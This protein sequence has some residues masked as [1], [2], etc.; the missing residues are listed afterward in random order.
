[1]DRIHGSNGDRSSWA[2]RRGR[3]GGGRVRRGPIAELATV[4][5]TVLTAGLGKSSQKP[6]EENGKL[7]E[8]LHH[9]EF[10]GQ[11]YVMWQMCN[12]GITAKQS[13]LSKISCSSGW[14]F[15]FR[16]LFLVSR[17]G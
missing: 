2:D 4:K 12:A 9:D 14:S 15:E 13:M 17:G 1:M 5:V 8:R 7:A 16:F 3:A 10:C 6:H 11:G